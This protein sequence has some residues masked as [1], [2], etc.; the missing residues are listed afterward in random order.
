MRDDILRPV[1][2]MGV[3]VPNGNALDTTVEGGKG[4]DSY[5]AEITETHRSI[6]RRVMPR[7]SHEAKGALPADAGKRG[8]DRCA[9]GR[10]R[11]VIDP[12][13]S[14]RINI[15]IVH[16]SSYLLHV[17]TRMGAQQITFLRRLRLAPFP[18]SM[19]IFQDGNGANDS[20]RAFWMSRGRILRATWIVK[21]NHSDSL[22]LT[23]AIV[24][25]QARSRER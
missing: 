2:V 24:H 12:W 21:N 16:C 22:E 9:G 18:V 15:K 20:L 11:M 23:D 5:V 10:D 1:P 7:R 4:R 6:P 25:R 17:I 19:S 13:I 3:K 14:R 8:L